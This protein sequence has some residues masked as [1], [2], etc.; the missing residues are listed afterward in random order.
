MTEGHETSF[1]V[2]DNIS[3]PA[4]AEKVASIFGDRMPPVAAAP[5]EGTVTRFMRWGGRDR[6]VS[7]NDTTRLGRR[8]AAVTSA[9]ENEWPV[10]AL[11]R[12]G[13][14]AANVAGRW[15]GSMDD[16]LDDVGL[17]QAANLSQWYGA[18]ES[19][20]SSPLRRAAATAAALHAGPRFHAGLVEL[21]F[22]DWEGLTTD[23]IRA[24]GPLFDQ[25]FIDGTDHPRGQT[26][27]TWR[28]LESRMQKALGEID[29]SPGKITGV[30][31]HGA[32]IRA[33]ITS[34]TDG[35]WAA[36]GGLLTP[37]NTSVTHLVMSDPP[38][39]ADYALA[40]HL[41]GMDT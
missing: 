23:E 12:H 19:V 40:P 37:P 8:P 41:E 20:W 5:E 17:Q 39:V 31:T 30:V 9:L 2:G 4:L 38:V 15:Q 25:I 11:I 33:V 3:A 6:L 26:G 21:R 22:G 18:L 29:P 36:A 13:R 10:V 32:A 27:E 28:V 7:Y 34:L 24:T 14:T 35:G 1:V 16:A